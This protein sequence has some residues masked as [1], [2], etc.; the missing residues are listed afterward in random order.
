MTSEIP[1]MIMR[2]G[3]LRSVL[4]LA[5]CLIFV[6][7]GVF[8]GRS[9]KWIGWLCAAF[10]GLGIPLAII[11]LIPGASYLEVRSDGFEICHVFRKRFI[12]WSMVD[13]FHII[14]VTPMSWSKTK[15]V[16]FDLLHPT[17]RA[18]MGQ[19][20]SKTLAGSEDMLPDNYG[21]K[22]EDLVEIMNAGLKKARERSN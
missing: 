10:F 13:K 6:V 15:R 5:G 1:S 7:A 3:K 17:E 16:G 21:K 19:E 20:L 18:S 22:A 4:L 2:P 14:D 12:P 9:G 8:M 11:Q